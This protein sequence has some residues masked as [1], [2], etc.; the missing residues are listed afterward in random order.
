MSTTPRRRF[1]SLSLAACAAGIIAYRVHRRHKPGHIGYGKSPRQRLNVYTPQSRT[2]T[3]HPVVVYFYGGAWQ[4][5]ALADARPVAQ[6]L[7]AHGIVTITPDYRVYP[8]TVFPAFLEDPA[9]A[10][11]WTR[12]HVHEFG[13][14]H[15]RI[16][17][18][19]HSSG[20]HMAAMLAT[21][22]QYLAGQ[23]MSNTSL[24]GM[25]GLAGPYAAIPTHDPHMDEIFPAA[26]R[27]QALP[28]ALVT[29]NEPPI[30]LAAGTADTDVD[31]ANSDRFADALRA[32]GDTVELKKYPGY[33]HDTIIKSFS[34]APNAVSPVLADVTAFIAEH[35]RC[36]LTT[37]ADKPHLSSS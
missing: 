27:Q 32:H 12:D 31:P 6:A 16:F 35:Q 8:Q 4:G 28:I 15:D 24:S 9:A 30:L 19:G 14:N 3:T 29:G 21:D 17:V 20:A 18:M 22:P 34:A 25:I 10:V 36:D 5:G 2:G 23:G 11:R 26:L 33:G 37:S 7:A 1:I 13:G